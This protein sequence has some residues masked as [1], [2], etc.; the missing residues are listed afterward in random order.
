MWEGYDDNLGEALADLNGAFGELEGFGVLTGGVKLAVP[1]LIGGGVTFGTAAAL[2]YFLK[3]AEPTTK[4]A[5]LP[6]KWLIGGGVGA[7]VGIGLNLATESMK[8]EGALLAATS[9]VT[10]LAGWGMQQ[11]DAPA[12]AGLN[13]Y[14]YR[15]LGAYRTAANPFGQGNLG[16]YRLGSP[17][18]A[19]SGTGFGSPAAAA[20]GNVVM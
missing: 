7:I 13:A 4:A 2:G 6:Y 14:R 3:D 16:S 18:T 1:V 17:K 8:A 11:L 10:A 12:V 19:L 9:V 20:M 5:W 15:Q